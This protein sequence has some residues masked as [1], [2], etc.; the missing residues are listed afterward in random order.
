MQGA[1]AP[2]GVGKVK[3]VGVIIEKF[4]EVCVASSETW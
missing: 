2:R 3:C 4:K 1:G